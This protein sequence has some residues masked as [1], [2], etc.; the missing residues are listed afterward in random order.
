[1]FISRL[2]A[3]KALVLAGIV[4][5]LVVGCNGANVAESPLASANVQEITKVAD[6]NTTPPKHWE[7]LTFAADKQAVNNDLIALAKAVAVTVNDGAMQQALH[8]AALERFDGDTEVLWSA[9][10]NNSS[11][12]AR[13]AQSNARNWSALVAQKADKSVFASSEAVSAAV[14]RASK[15]YNANVHLF[16]FNAEKWDKT[17]TPIV[18]FVPVGCDPEKENIILSGYDA[19]GKKYAVDKEFALKNPVIVI[20]ANERTDASG[21]VLDAYNQAKLAQAAKE[22]QATLNSSTNLK[23]IWTSFSGQSNEGW[24]NGNPEFWVSIHSVNAQNPGAESFQWGSWE[25]GVDWWRCDGQQIYWDGW[26]IRQA[27]WNQS[28]YRTF[29]FKWMERDPGI[30]WEFSVSGSYKVDNGSVTVTGKVSGKDEDDNLGIATV[31]FDDPVG[32]RTYYTG[33]PSFQLEW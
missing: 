33:M 25:C 11:I 32:S 20:N 2:K 8:K 12:N 26:W 17:T 30:N 27:T 23:L 21:Q 19:K 13:A 16:W 9:L 15:A 3:V 5:G 29:V 18:A 22:R 6:K 4:G 31:N 10:N 14:N 28:L 1:M 7:T 24:F